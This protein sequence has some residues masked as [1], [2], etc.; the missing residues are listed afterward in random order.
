LLGTIYIQMTHNDR[1]TAQRVSALEA[2][3]SDTTDRLK[4]LEDKLD[5]IFEGVLGHKP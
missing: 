5:L 1:E 4:R 2:H 3:Q